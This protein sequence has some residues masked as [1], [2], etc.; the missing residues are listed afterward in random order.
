LNAKVEQVCPRCGAPSS[1]TS[2]L[3]EQHRLDAA[4]RQSRW[5][6]KHRQARR[7]DKRCAFC[8]VPSPTYRCKLCKEKRRRWNAGLRIDPSVGREPDATVDAEPTEERT[9]VGPVCRSPVSN[10]HEAGRRGPLSSAVAAVAGIVLGGGAGERAPGA[11]R[12]AAVPLP[13][14]RCCRCYPE[15][16]TGGPHHG[17]E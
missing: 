8:D 3:C 6:A 7:D 11:G 15:P 5:S 14:G 2:V 9:T 12:R 17:R 16:A 13:P 10:D 1:E 4:A